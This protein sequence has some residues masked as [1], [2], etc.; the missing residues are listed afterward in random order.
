PLPTRLSADLCSTGFSGWD[1]DGNPVVLTA[2][3]C[4]KII[5]EDTNEFDGDTTVGETEQPS[6]AEA[7]GGEGFQA[8]GE[9]VIGKWG[10][11]KFGGDMLEGADKYEWP[12]TSES[13]I[14]FALLDDQA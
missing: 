4:S 3:H 1:G 8:S 11:H 14:D 7:N 5:N 13:D 2:G 12:N 6:T 9:G 10:F